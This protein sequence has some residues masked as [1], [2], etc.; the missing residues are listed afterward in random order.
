MGGSKAGK[1]RIMS[2]RGFATISYWADDLP[3]AIAWYTELL[4]VEPYFQRSGPD[5]RPA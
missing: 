1:G 3:A 5:G 4:G 2:L